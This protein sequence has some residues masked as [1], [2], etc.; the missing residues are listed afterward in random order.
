MPQSTVRDPGQAAPLRDY[1]VPAA[2]E[3]PSNVAYLEHL[4]KS[5]AP[6]L[7]RLA[8]NENTEPPSPNVRAALA[9]AYD[10]ANLSPPPVPP[11]RLGLAGRPGGGRGQGLVP[12]G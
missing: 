10:D 4:S 11:L 3:L 6:G 8:S 2:L 12:A 1:L 9:A 5:A 7:I